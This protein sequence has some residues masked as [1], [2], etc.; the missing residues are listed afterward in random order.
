MIQSTTKGV[1]KMKK[2]TTMILT[3]MLGLS[4]VSGV[5]GCSST[6]STD[7]PAA[8]TDNGGSQQDAT[9]T[10]HLVF[11]DALIAESHIADQFAAQKG[12]ENGKDVVYSVPTSSEDDSL[13]LLSNYWDASLAKTEYESYLGDKA[14]L[15]KAN[16][17]FKAKAASAKTDFTPV[18]RVADDSKLGANDLSSAKAKFEDVKFTQQDDKYIL[19]YKGLKYTLQKQGNAY[20]IVAKEGQLQK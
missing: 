8:T 15:E 11:A 9:K 3:A 14:L 17:A 19:E 16:A 13:K 12:L 2:F 4:V 5:V 6:T 1:N 20:K 7:K 10:Q 18:D